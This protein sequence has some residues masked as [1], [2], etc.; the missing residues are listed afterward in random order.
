MRLY[1]PPPD[2][3]GRLAILSRHLSLMPLTPSPFPPPTLSTLVERTE[4]FTGADVVALCRRAAMC[5]LQRNAREGTETLIGWGDFEE[6]LK[7]VGPSVNAFQL[8]RYTSFGVVASE[9]TS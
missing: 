5:A 7:S 3:P 9:M 1:V 4:G 8:M 2:A 6:A